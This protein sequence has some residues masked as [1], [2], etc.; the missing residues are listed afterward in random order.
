MSGIS[1][2]I[3][4]PSPAGTVGRRTQ[5]SGSVTAY[6]G[7]LDSVQIQFGAG[8]P[9]VD[10]TTEFG[11]FQWSWEGLI[12][13]N[14][15]PGQAFQILIYATGE[16]TINRDTRF[17]DGTASVNVVLE[18]M[19]PVLT[20]DPFQS[21][22][23][24]KQPP[25]SFTLKGTVTEGDSALYDVPQ[26]QCRIGNGP[27]TALAVSQGRWGVELQPGDYSVTVQASDK[28]GSATTVQT[29]VTVLGYPVP[30]GAD[31]NTKKTLAGVPTTS[32][33][34]SWTR[35]EPQ[36]ANADIG[37][38]TSARL[39]DPLWLMTRQW[40]MGEFQGEDT[41]SPVQARVR[42][43]NA[44]L[45]R[46]YFGELPGDNKAPPY[47][48]TLVPLEVMV[49]RRRMRPADADDARMLTL[50]VDAGLHF[51]RMLELSAAGKKYRLAFIAQYAMQPLPA[52][53]AAD[54]ATA[55][56]VQTMA[57]R[58]PDARRLA[59]AFRRLDTPQTVFDPSLNIAAA[60]LAAVRQVAAA[61][62]AWYD[63]LFP[64]PAAPSQDAWMSS[65][66][67]YAVSVAVRLSA[68]PQ[69]ALTFS[70]SEFDGGRLDWS[71]FDINE[72]SHVDTTGDQAPLALNETT[73]PSPV[74]FHGMPAPRFWE[75][76]DAK[77]AYGLLPAGPTDLAH[78]LMIEYA[79]T[80]GNDWYVVP[81]TV[82]VGTVTRV[83]SL[84][85]ADTFGVRSLLRPIGDPALPTPYFSMWQS[86][87]MR[88][89]GDQIGEK[90]IDGNPVGGP[91]PNRFFL[92][93]TIGQ[94]IDG[95]TLEDVLFMR[96]EM[97]NLAWGIERGIEGATETPVKLAGGPPPTGAALPSA[98]PGAPPRYLLSTTV[99][100]N[101]IPLLPVQL[102]GQGKPIPQPSQ[103]DDRVKQVARLQRGAVLQPDGTAQSHPA[104]SEALKALGA[105]LLYDE[106]VPREGVRITRRRR[107]T[108]WT[109]GSTWVWTAFRN[110]AGSGEG[111]SGLRFDNLLGEDDPGQ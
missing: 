37:S 86:T 67:E 98:A 39:F 44:T 13:N 1:I 3:S 26:V 35:L 12:P 45:T 99:P 30:A 22:I 75:I 11:S 101:W 84:V 64:E 36:C 68:Q 74:S 65:R 10:A 87:R 108:R 106:E 62:L 4:Y 33:V 104:Q 97:A 73:V 82:P 7:T 90:Q 61:W 81:L 76:E 89:A 52:Q 21:P 25:N 2:S 96:D 105:A 9:T 54:D 56:F 8:G 24:V 41:G 70:A 28:F 59:Q 103:Q 109:D 55:R 31:P 49:E 85:V 46:C 100:D 14:I 91:V 107:M 66:L 95:A 71:S 79:S 50:A 5:I 47:D 20:V 38:S 53:K 80:Y 83:D 92:P 111:S 72:K 19:V 29:S 69:D 77:V 93:P 27:F 40:Q 15:R 102:D 58:A 32:S 88:H 110:E 94:S 48:P 43:T 16:K 17:V 51:L 63:G 34:T 57:G 60:D 42:A 23:V 18:N 6:K 78:L